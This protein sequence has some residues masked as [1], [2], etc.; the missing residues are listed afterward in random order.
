MHGSVPIVTIT[1]SYDE[2]CALLGREEGCELQRDTV[3]MGR[4]TS[5]RGSVC[6]KGR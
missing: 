2:G 4:E 1:E 6:V 5:V 3:Y